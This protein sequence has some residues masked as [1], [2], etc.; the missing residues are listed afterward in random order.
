ME[1]MSSRTGLFARR[2]LA[3]L[4]ILSIGLLCCA[5]LISMV[6]IIFIG[7][8]DNLPL[9]ISTI[10][11]FVVTGLMATGVRWIPLLGALFSGVFLV[12]M[13]LRPEVDFHMTHP[14]VGGFLAFVM[15]L[16]LFACFVTVFASSIS[17]TVQNF[18]QCERSMPRW[19]LSALTG[20][21]GIVV[22][23]ILI[24][25][26]AQPVPTTSALSTTSGGEAVVHMG[27]GSFLS[28]T[29]VVPKGGKLQLVDDGAF[30]HI[31]ANGSWVNGQPTPAQEN[32]APL[33]HNL[34]VNG[35]N[36]E[37]GPFATAGTFHIYCT[38]HPGMNLTII[39]R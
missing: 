6:L 10:V 15:D 19:V 28:S 16:L 25:A 12:L 23:G 34:Q 27:P 8:P 18:R 14:Q 20:V 39:V 11:L 31:L 9:L 22:G 26:I 30:V 21:A 7:W 4:S 3:A 29:V 32:G 33:L 37:L 36:V 2:P 24:A 38:I 1:T 5:G 13:F 17:A 35:N